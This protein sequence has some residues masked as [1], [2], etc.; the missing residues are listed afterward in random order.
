MKRILIVDDEVGATR[1]LKASLEQTG[2]YEVRVENWPEEAVAAAREFKPDLVLLDVL[3]PRMFGG[4]VAAALQTDPEL[5]RIPR[6]FLTGAVRRSVLQE[7]DGVISGDRYL[8]KPASLEEIIRC[9]EEELS[10]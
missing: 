6:V 7:H 9:I 2:H 10:K 3:M 1:L 5:A 4:N 8:A